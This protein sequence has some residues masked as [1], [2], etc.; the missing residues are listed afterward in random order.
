[1]LFQALQPSNREEVDEAGDAGTSTQDSVQVQT[2]DDAE[3]VVQPAIGREGICGSDGV[4][5]VACVLVYAQSACKNEH[6]FTAGDHRKMF[7]KPRT[8]C[9][10]RFL[11]T[12]S[13]GKARRIHK[14]TDTSREFGWESLG[15]R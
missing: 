1:M 10:R 11:F 15:P 4:E 6:V 12:P 7:W 5:V 14:K 2:V 8:W 9:A 3:L 13:R